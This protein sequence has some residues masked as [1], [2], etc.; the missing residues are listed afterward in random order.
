MAHLTVPELVKEVM[1]T[2][3]LTQAEL[4]EAIGKDQTTVSDWKRGRFEPDRLVVHILS[5]E[6]CREHFFAEGGGIQT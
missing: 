3:G 4:G 2:Y 6:D 1:D 5:C